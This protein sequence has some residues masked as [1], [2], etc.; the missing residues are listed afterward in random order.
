MMDH[1]PRFNEALDCAPI[2]LAFIFDIFNK[3]VHETKLSVPNIMKEIN[4]YNIHETGCKVI[5]E[6]IYS[7]LQYFSTSIK[8]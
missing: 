2:S 6:F 8:I 5:K 4:R 7:D 3:F 1:E